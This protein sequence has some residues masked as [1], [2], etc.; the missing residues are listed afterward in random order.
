MNEAVRLEGVTADPGGGGAVAGLDLVVQP[1]EIVGLVGDMQRVRTVMRLAAGVLEPIA[2]QVFIDGIPAA[3]R[4]VVALRRAAYFD[5][6]TLS[7]TPAGAAGLLSSLYPTW[8]EERF[9]AL[10]ARIGVSKHKPMELRG[11][12]G[13]RAAA[14]LGL[15]TGAAAVLLH[16]PVPKGFGPLL[17][18]RGTPESRQATLGTVVSAA[19]DAGTALVLGHWDASAL[20]GHVDRIVSVEPS[21]D[22]PSTSRPTTAAVSSSADGRQ[23]LALVGH[24]LRP[25]LQG[26]L[27]LPLLGGV[28]WVIASMAGND[29]EVLAS[30]V[31]PL[32]WYPLL[33]IWL[34]GWWSPVSAFGDG[35]NGAWGGLGGDLPVTPTTSIA[36]RILIA[37][38]RSVV[39]LLAVAYGAAVLNGAWALEGVS[40]LCT[41]S[42]PVGRSLAVALFAL[43]ALTPLAAASQ[44]I[45]PWRQRLGVQV[46][47]LLLATGAATWFWPGHETSP[48]LWGLAVSDPVVLALVILG[49]VLGFGWLLVGLPRQ[50]L[51]SVRGRSSWAA[52]PVAAGLA[53][54]AAIPAA[55]LRALPTPDWRDALAPEITVLDDDRFTVFGVTTRSSRAPAVGVLAVVDTRTWEGTELRPGIRR[56]EHAGD[57]WGR[58]WADGDDR[59]IDLAR[60]PD[61]PAIAESSRWQGKTSGAT[62]NPTTGLLTS[63]NLSGDHLWLEPTGRTGIVS[64]NERARGRWSVVRGADGV[65]EVHR[66]EPLEERTCPDGS[67]PQWRGL[68][69]C[70]EPGG[71]ALYW[72]H[73][74][75]RSTPPRRLPSL[76]AGLEMGE[77]S[78]ISPVEHGRFGFFSV[79][80]GPLMLLTLDGL[81]GWQEPVLI[82]VPAA[83]L[84]APVGEDRL[85]I[86]RSFGPRASDELLI[87]SATTG[88]CEA[89]PMR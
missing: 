61:G 84:I 88:R 8:S 20:E 66:S 32:S 53:L 27:E 59:W 49:A 62:W 74:H 6:Q 47:G 82:D 42:G 44:L 64:D 69:S 79:L 39:P 30:I 9:G 77:R 16:Q 68:M 71:P 11:A 5:A 22:R 89:P 85:L 34:G 36:S 52:L 33:S 86:Q 3:G 60:T 81:G 63:S 26:L 12:E 41:W 18:A 29:M 37:L 70:A 58:E 40:S 50:A 55:V 19:R 56:L 78:R 48:R 38:V 23:I 35:M 17:P 7:R 15:A 65:P 4:N 10:C 83:G 28:Y 54:C 13:A 2:G 21:P 80:E 73:D 25:T 46:G 14:A 51:G 87:C 1:G 24:G 57:L 43:T 76:P 72:D 75:D 31:V 67:S 45:T